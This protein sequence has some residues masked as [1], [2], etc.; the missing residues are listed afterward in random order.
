MATDGTSMNLQEHLTKISKHDDFPKDHVNYLKQLKESGFEPKVIYDIGANVLYWTR[1]AR[2][3]WPEADIVL[4]D[5]YRPVEFLYSGYKHHIGVLSDKDDEVVKFYIND[6]YPGGNSY[7][8]EIGS[9]RNIF[10]KENYALYKTERLDSVVEENEFPLPDLVKLDVQGSEKDI[11]AG[12]LHT[13]SHAKHLIVE[14]QTIEYNEGAPNMEETLP[15]IESLGWKCTAPLFCN[16]GP[17]G[18][19]GFTRI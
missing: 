9:Y 6:M 19:Y 17:D 10:P 11:I 7:Y 12:G 14:L 18:D 1:H 3:L 13:L 2:E 4:F 8:R 15:Y 5:A 16:N